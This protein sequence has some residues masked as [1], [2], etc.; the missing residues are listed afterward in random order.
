MESMGLIDAIWRCRSRSW[1]RFFRPNWVFAP[2]RTCCRPA[3][4]G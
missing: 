2:V 1:D 3:T 4:D